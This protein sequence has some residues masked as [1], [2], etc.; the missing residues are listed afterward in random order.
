MKLFWNENRSSC[1]LLQPVLELPAVLAGSV[2]ARGLVWFLAALMHLLLL[3][4]TSRAAMV[5]A[6]TAEYDGEAACLFP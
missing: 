1:V 5:Q 3:V 6:G 4:D 2:Q